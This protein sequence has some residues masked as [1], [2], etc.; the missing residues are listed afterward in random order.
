MKRK[1]CHISALYVL[2]IFF[3]SLPI[4]AQETITPIDRSGRIVTDKYSVVYSMDLPPG[5]SP[6]TNIMGN[7][8]LKVLMEVYPDPSDRE[9]L[10]I[11]D[12]IDI[13]TM[14]D[15]SSSTAELLDREMDQSPLEYT[16]RSIRHHSI[17]MS[18]LGVS[19]ADTTKYIGGSFRMEVPRMNPGSNIKITPL[20]EDSELVVQAS[21]LHFFVF[22]EHVTDS[23]SRMKGAWRI[24]DFIMAFFLSKYCMNP[25]IT[26]ASIVPS[27]IY[28][29]STARYRL[30]VAYGI[31]SKGYRE[32]YEMSGEMRIDKIRRQISLITLRGYCEIK[33]GSS[34]FITHGV[35]ECTLS[36]QSNSSHHNHLRRV[37]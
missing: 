8:M 28:D 32:F 23:L 3:Y 16:I 36:V 15:M 7:E 5:M 24:P 6:K 14:I 26:H 21:N 27:E 9:G 19:G 37:E 30:E 10:Q 12:S 33:I 2:I 13:N 29:A 31:T 1:S 4:A 17:S 35:G 11:V 22:E 34:G 20:P 18:H 25:T